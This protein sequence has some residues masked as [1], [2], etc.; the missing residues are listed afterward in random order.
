VYMAAIEIGRICVKTHGREVGVRCVIVDLIDDNFVLITGP[1]DVN[2]VKR[3]R[4]NVK[5]IEATNDK[6]SLKKGASD[7]E[8]KKTLQAAGKLESMKEKIK[9][10]V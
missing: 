3:R 9:I 7:D 4:V 5:H 1:K 10:K 2:G 8:V 6:I